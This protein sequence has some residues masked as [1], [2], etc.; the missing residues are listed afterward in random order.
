VPATVEILPTGP[1]RLEIAV[2]GA[3]LSGMAM[4]HELVA[5]G[6]E[7]VGAARTFPDYR[8]FLL[9]GTV[10]P[11]PGLVQAPGHAGPGIDIEVWSLPVAAFGTFVSRI[12][13]PLGIGKIVLADGSHVSG[14]LCEA[15]AVDG[16]REITAFGGWRAFLA[17]QTLR[18]G[19]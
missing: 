17:E 11:K 8:L 6:G 12:P 15:W 19:G 7:W 10:P 1:E 9:P 4:N 16:A 14:F 2:I 13:S 3:H 5:L 18:A